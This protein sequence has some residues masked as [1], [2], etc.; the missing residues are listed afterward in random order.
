[1]LVD[2]D[3]GKK[4]GKAART[5]RDAGCQ[6]VL[7][8]RQTLRNLGKMNR[9]DHRKLTVFD[10]RSPWSA[11]IASSTAGLGTRRTRDHVRDVG[12]R[13]HGPVV[14]AVQSTFSENWVDATGELFVGDDVF[15]PLQREGEVAAH[16]AARQARRLDAGGQD[17][18]PPDAVPGA[19]AAVDPEPVLP[20]RPGGDQGR[21]ARRSSAASTC[22]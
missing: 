19:P 14:Q 2:S 16:V 5:M 22:A 3:G 1:M 10:G 11:V 4:M 7:F 17:P 15:P 8:H 13:L 18:A 20:A 9:R 12:V 21:C 6:F